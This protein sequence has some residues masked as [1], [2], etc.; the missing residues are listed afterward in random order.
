[1]A[2]MKAFPLNNSDYSY[3]AKDVMHFFAGRKSGVFKFDDNLK[4]VK[5][6][7]MDVIVKSGYCWLG[8]GTEYGLA[9]WLDSNTNITLDAGDTLYPRKDRVVVSW[10]SANQ[11]ALPTVSIKKGTPASNPVGMDLTNDESHMEICLAEVLVPI[12]A[13]DVDS[14][15]ITDTRQNE[16]LCGRVVDFEFSV[17]STNEIDSMMA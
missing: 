13:S 14:M 10:D 1:M 7:N 9:I 6:S 17:I 3:N 5:G 16:V 12:G 4:V 15:T 11:S 2:N 8:Y